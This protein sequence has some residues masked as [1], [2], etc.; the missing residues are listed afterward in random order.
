[1]CFLLLGIELQ[2]VR[3]AESAVSAFPAAPFLAIQRNS[4]GPSKTP[5]WFHML[6]LRE[7]KQ[8][9]DGGGAGFSEPQ[10]RKQGI[11]LSLEMLVRRN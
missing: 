7:A 5:Y 2:V 9:A 10:L 1:M 8:R 4:M 6:V 11:F 3:V